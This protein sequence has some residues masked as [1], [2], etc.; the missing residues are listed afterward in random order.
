MGCG[1]CGRTEPQVELPDTPQ[2]LMAMAVEQMK[3]VND[4]LDTIRDR[5]TAEAAQAK[6][7]TI[8]REM[9]SLAERQTAY[10]TPDAETTKRLQ[11]EFALPYK[12]EVDRWNAN[13]SRLRADP[14]TAWI[15]DR[16][17]PS[18]EKERQ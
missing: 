10:G 8:Y 2:N 1:G 14:E 4:T 7:D 18:L 15:L 6:L 5:A 12:T 3:R 13:R 11:T 16:G 9:H 17:M